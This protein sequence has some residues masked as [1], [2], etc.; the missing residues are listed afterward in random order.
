[1]RTFRKWPAL[2]LIAAATVLL[3]ALIAAGATRLQPTNGTTAPALNNA[4][5]ANISAEA[6][7]IRD[8]LDATMRDYRLGNY[9]A[10]FREARS[11]YL[12]HFES[13]EVPL[14]AVNPDLTLDMEYR[15]ADLRTK[16]QQ[17][18]DAATVEQ[19]ELSVRAGV[20]EIDTSFNGTGVA[21]PALAFTSGF[22]IIFREGLEAT[23]VIAA[24][25][26]YL[27]AGQSRALGRYLLY[28]VG[29]AMAASLFSWAVV[30]YLISITPVA[31]ELLEAAISVLAVG[32]L[33]WVNFWLLRRADQKRWMEFMRARAWA[34]MTS[35]SAIGLAALGFTAVY[36]E[37][38]ETALFYEALAFIGQQVGL[39]I[40]LGFVVGVI[41][42]AVIAYGLLRTGQK[43]PVVRFLK[44]AVPLLMVMSVA[45][46][47]T[48]VQQLQGSG[49][50]G[51]TSLLGIVP[52]LPNLVAQLTGIHPTVE[53]IGA[54]LI[55]TLIYLAGFVWMRLHSPTSRN[56][57]P[58]NRVTPPKNAVPVS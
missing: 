42:L 52:R 33:F 57:A 44:I 43:M 50:I 15:F 56:A 47:G 45:F 58:T 11:A 18:A 30:H 31:R 17:G 53:T 16:M 55:L 6:A 25:F 36:R 51:A 1:M 54:Q 4:S 20:D 37:G 23:L 49:F 39:Y 29:A 13:I 46:I 41:A 8:S 48:A 10:A 24:L 9:Q 35:G 40:A 12:D 27:Q 19:I 38:L 2:A 7:A 14:R 22:T 32:V 5:A 28:G 21:A 3:I 26:A 34:A